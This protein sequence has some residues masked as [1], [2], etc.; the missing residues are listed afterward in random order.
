MLHHLVTARLPHIGTLIQW[1]LSWS[2]LQVLH[3]NWRLSA[4]IVNNDDLVQNLCRR[5]VEDGL[6]G[7]ELRKWSVAACDLNRWMWVGGDSWHLALL[8]H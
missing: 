3:S 2:D 6:H 7:F 5:R 1:E 4:A 8:L